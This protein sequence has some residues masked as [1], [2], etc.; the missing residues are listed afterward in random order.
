MS[1]RTTRRLLLS[2][3]YA[4]T[5]ALLFV[6]WKAYPDRPISTAA[7]ERR[8]REDVLS[9][10]INQ[11]FSDYR[12]YMALWNRAPVGLAVVDE[13]GRFLQVNRK[14]ADLTGYSP[15]ELQRMTYQEI[16]DPADVAGDEAMAEEVA[17]GKIDG[18]P[19]VK[20]YIHK[21]KYPVL[22]L[23]NVQGIYRDDGSFAFYLV[24]CFKL[25]E[26]R[27]MVAE[28]TSESIVIRPKV[29]LGSYIGD[30]LKWILPMI[31]GLIVF[32]FHFGR[33]VQLF[34][35]RRSLEVDEA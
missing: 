6:A 8:I 22:V 19:Y 31:G 32:I 17:S 15:Y 23:V 29:D 27:D 25:V 2:I 7:T 30:N 28:T 1:R 13:S 11:A 20:Y 35:D 34:L 14:Y 21:Q 5:G 18:Y 33:K 10:D 24:H 4:V 3:L 9:L 12:I 16:T 26:W